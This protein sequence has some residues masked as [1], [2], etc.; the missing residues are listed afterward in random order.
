[1]QI[2][3]TFRDT[4]NGRWGL[5]LTCSQTRRKDRLECLLLIGSLAC[6]A[7]WIIGVTARCAGYHVEYGSKRKAASALS[8]LSLARWWIDEF[9]DLDIPTALV[10]DALD[11]LSSIAKQA[12]I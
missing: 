10:D 12:S 4:K 11:I 3:Q 5:G 9:P 7:L 8:I 1:M 2:E 6:Y